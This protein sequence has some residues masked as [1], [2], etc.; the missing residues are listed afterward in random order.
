MTT[1]I[2]PEEI[3]QIEAQLWAE[4]KLALTKQEVTLFGGPGHGSVFNVPNGVTELSVETAFGPSWYRRD[5]ENEAQ[6]IPRL[7]VS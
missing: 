5:P 3:E 4:N 1:E 7:D 2:N 6:F